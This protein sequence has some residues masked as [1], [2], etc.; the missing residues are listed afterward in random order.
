MKLDLFNGNCWVILQVLAKVDL[1]S[2]EKEKLKF[3]NTKFIDPTHV[4]TTKLKTG[5]LVGKLFNLFH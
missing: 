2:I 5:A 3:Y 1:P 4:G